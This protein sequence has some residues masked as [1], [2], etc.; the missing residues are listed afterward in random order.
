VSPPIR[1][2][3][4]VGVDGTEA[5]ARALRW[6]VHEAA[7]HG[8][9]VTAVAAWHAEDIDRPTDADLDAERSRALRLLREA[10]HEA[11]T[12]EPSVPVH[13]VAEFGRPG[14]VLLENAR[15]ADLLVLGSHGY[16]RLF[17]ATHGTTAKE[18]VG[19]ASCPVVV[20][21]ELRPAGVPTGRA[22]RQPVLK[23]SR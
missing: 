3:V 14:P 8:G 20:L 15:G 10:V 9:V 7:A 4:V 6:A 17:P 16:G 12:A 13:T 21:P 11:H 23:E 19:T 18:C 2:R 22:T 1:Y 5:G